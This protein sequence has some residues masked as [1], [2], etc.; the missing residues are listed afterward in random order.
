[1]DDRRLPRDSL[2][3]YSGVNPADISK[4]PETPVVPVTES[5]ERKP[6]RMPWYNP[7]G[8]P[9]WMQVLCPCLL[10]ATIGGIIA[11]AVVGV[12]DN[13]Y[14]KYTPLTYH[15]QDAYAGP[16]FF[17]QFTYFT[18]EDP[19]DGFVAYVSRETAT[20][21][22]LT[23]ATDTSAILRVDSFTPNTL[24]GRNSVRVESKKAYD[25][26]LFI[27]DI[28]HT[29]Y[30]CGTWPALWMTDGANWPSNGEID[31]LETTNEGSNG[32]AVTLH[33]TP[34]CKMNVKRKETGEAVY[35]TCENSTNG[36]SGCGVLGGSET[37]GAEFNEN[38][39]GV[40][41]LLLSY[42]QCNI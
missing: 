27:F 30:G 15:L 4:T 34:G 24:G 39:G 21:F 9:L 7:R 29:P 38:G 13:R 41:L 17:E 35:T 12:K 11:G 18:E 25:T 14:P 36:N 20:N 6:A 37:Y 40:S 8:W 28:I 2:E 23:Y 1:M 31:I 42:L 32:N 19:T 33:T 5:P 26:G 16:S 22:N 10:L 3:R